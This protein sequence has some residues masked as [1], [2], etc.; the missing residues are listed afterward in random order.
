[1]EKLSRKQLDY[2]IRDE[3][4][5]VREYEKLGLGKIASEERRHMN[6]FKMLK[7]RR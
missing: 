7:A 1:M 2:F 6:F 4:M 3:R 5:A